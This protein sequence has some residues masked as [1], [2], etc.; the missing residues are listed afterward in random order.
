MQ[1]K[2]VPPAPDSLAAALSV[3][4]AVPLVPKPEGD[5]C[6]RVVDRTSVP[7]RGTASAWLAFLAALGL[8][9]KTNR[10][11]ARIQSVPDESEL[12]DAF[13][14]N[15]FL[16]S[17]VLDALDDTDPRTPVEVFDSVRGR[18]PRWERSKREDW[19][20][21]WTDRVERRLDWAVLFGLVTATDGGYLRA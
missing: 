21:F 16:A 1:R 18:V 10:G 9:E 3:R 7:D 19:P 11:F 17:E 8:V 5:C 14:G 2:P 4:D 12:A 20:A 15:V 6:R 13:T